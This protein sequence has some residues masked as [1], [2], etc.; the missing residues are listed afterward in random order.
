MFFSVLI[1][2]MMIVNAVSRVMLMRWF[3]PSYSGVPRWGLV[4][5]SK[6]SRYKW[7]SGAAPYPS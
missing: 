4:S 2:V 3:G 6:W 1:G 7:N 5:L